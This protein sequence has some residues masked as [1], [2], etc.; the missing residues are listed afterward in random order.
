MAVAILISVQLMCTETIRFLSSA[1]NEDTQS[2]GYTQMGRWIV[3]CGDD[4][5][6]LLL[7]ITQR[8]CGT[9]L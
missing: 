1:E 8:L 6:Y 2:A 5:A 9:K 4:G 7:H 3:N